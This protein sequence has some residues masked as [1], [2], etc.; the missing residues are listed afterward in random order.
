MTQSISSTNAVGYSG[1]LLALLLQNE[2]NQSES[3]RL[4]RDAARQR[5]MDESQKQVDALH[6]AADAT[7]TGAAISAGMSIAG[8]ACTIAGAFDEYDANTAKAQ[9][10]GLDC[11]SPSFQSDA[12]F[13]NQAFA[14]AH[15]S[16]QLYGTVGDTA[17]KLAG[18]ANAFLGTRVAD[19]DQAIAKHHETLAEQA[20]WEAGDASDT[21]DKADK[22]GDNEL[23][24][25]QSIQ[26]DEHSSTNA[27]I[28]RI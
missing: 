21:I 17:S 11:H 12:Q 2:D 22:R 10:S 20:R 16:A 28:G 24:I 1:E 7:A 25:L 14:D 19:D 8:G 15:K 4:S 13:L 3:A 5:F 6:A 23:Q 27:I 26:S 9:L 18:P